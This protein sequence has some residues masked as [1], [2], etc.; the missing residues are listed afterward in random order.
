[1]SRVK[2]P[3]SHVTCSCQTTQNPL[4]T[5]SHS[6]WR[7]M[8]ELPWDDRLPFFRCEAGSLLTQAESILLRTTFLDKSVARGVADSRMVREESVHSRLQKQFHFRSQVSQHVWIGTEAEV[9]GQ[10]RILGAERPSVH[11]KVVRVRLS[12]Y[13]CPWQETPVR[14]SWKDQILI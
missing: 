9:Q 5:S 7:W 3:V 2:C 6:H 13:V 10:K 4:T 14:P 11:D 1:M 8:A 12:D